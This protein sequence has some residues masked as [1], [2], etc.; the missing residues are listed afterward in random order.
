MAADAAG[1]F[2][3][4]RNAPAVILDHADKGQVPNGGKVHRLV[5][6]ALVHRAFTDESHGHARL[7]L[8]LAAERRPHGGAHTLRDNTGAGKVHIVIK[9]MHMPAATTG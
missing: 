8:H 1:G 9:E 4:D 7:A 5:P 3:G 2:F 6:A